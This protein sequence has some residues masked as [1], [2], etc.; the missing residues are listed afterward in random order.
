[1]KVEKNRIR[2]VSKSPAISHRQ[3]WQI[4]IF[5]VSFLLVSITANAQEG[6]YFQHD[7]WLLVCDNTGTCRAHAGNVGADLLLIRKAGP[8]QPVA[9]LVQVAVDDE[10]NA[11]EN[12]DLELFLDG[13][14]QGTVSMTM[15]QDDD[16]NS[17]QAESFYGRLLPT[18]TEALIKA[19]QKDSTIEFDYGGQRYSLPD[20][21]ATAV[22]LKMDEFQQRLNTTG[23]LVRKGNKSEGDVLTPQSAKRVQIAKPVDSSYSNEAAEMLR[24]QS[25]E[26]LAALQDAKEQTRLGEL[27]EFMWCEDLKS[28]D[29][30]EFEFHAARLTND[31]L[32]VSAQCWMAAYN[33]GVGFWVVNSKPPFEPVNVTTAGDSYEGG[34]ISLSHKSRGLGDCWQSAEWAWTGED[35]AMTQLETSGQCAGVGG[36]SWRMPLLVTEPK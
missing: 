30:D 16:E 22:L 2:V 28:I 11:T 7:D 29:A 13:K 4:V 12:A 33:W 1:M 15:R 5:C 25:D 6:E 35:F 20:A 3:V 17:L 9:A 10:D 34:N 26:L 8:N 19:L 14:S 31:K 18:Q 23:A 24:E 21:G 32:L 36:G 27:N